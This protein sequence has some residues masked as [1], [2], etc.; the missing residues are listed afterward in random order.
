LS[1]ARL[2]TV[3]GAAHFP[4]LDNPELVFLS[5]ETFLRGE[6][7]GSAEKISASSNTR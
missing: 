4:W 1:D 5:I 2:V 6:W 3:T 7:P